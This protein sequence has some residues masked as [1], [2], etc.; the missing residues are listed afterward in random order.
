MALI[1]LFTTRRTGRLLRAD[2]ALLAAAAARIAARD[3]EGP[4]FGGA[5]VRE[6]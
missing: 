1:V 5:Q 2:A 6:Y 4:P 3:L